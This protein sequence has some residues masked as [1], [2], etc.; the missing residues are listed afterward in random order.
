MW[1]YKKEIIKEGT[2]KFQIHDNERFINYKE[3]INLTQ[4]SF[5]FIHFFIELLKECEFDA[6][7]WE[8]KPIDEKNLDEKFEFVL[9][10]SSQLSS[11]KSNIT[12]FKPYFEKNLEVVSFRNLRGDA[13]L[14]IPSKISDENNYTHL[15][16]FIRKAPQHQII[17]FWKKVAEDYSKIIDN[18]KK[19]L[20][21]AGLGVH[22]LHVRIDSKPK[23]YRYTEY[24]L[25]K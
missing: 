1:H 4:N 25:I 12:P 14:I 9:V 18:E 10:F 20:S 21:T 24:K 11:L 19:W 7:Y 5:E 2:I 8:V 15:A 3:W 16:K 17:K 23:Y 6:Y 22:W 13:Q